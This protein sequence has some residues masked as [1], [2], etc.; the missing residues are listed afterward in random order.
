MGTI[1]KILLISFVAD[2]LLQLKDVKNNKH[3]SSVMLLVHV[4][5]WSVP[6][7][8]VASILIFNE[9]GAFT[10]LW[11]LYWWITILV[12][13]FSIEWCTVRQWTNLYYQKN[14]SAAAF[15]IHME[16]FL[17]NAVIILSFMY[18]QGGM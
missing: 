4:L 18:F 2:Q 15:W 14:K 9:S 8:V 7:F 13:H 11:P 1:L 5:T 17:L 12:A 16:H 3:K 6:M 10:S